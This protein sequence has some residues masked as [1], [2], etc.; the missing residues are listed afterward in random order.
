MLPHYA[1]RLSMSF[2]AVRLGPWRR[3][4]ALGVGALLLA[5][6]GVGQLIDNVYSR[7]RV[8]YRVGALPGD[9]QLRRARGADL[10]WHHREGGMAAASAQCPSGEDVPLDVLTRHLLFGFESQRQLGRALLT[11]D[12]R[13]ALRTHLRAEFDGVP[14]EL[15][16]VVLKKDGCTY[17]LQLI[18]A[19]G[20]FAARQR[21][22]DAFVQGFTTQPAAPT[23]AER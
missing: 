10:V 13:Q 23:G 22:F 5:C 2:L 16:L 8:R 12:G 19:P 1:T 11:L 18:A 17:D 3:A 14:I 4:V 20:P 21:D 9:W 15:D 7:G 6:S